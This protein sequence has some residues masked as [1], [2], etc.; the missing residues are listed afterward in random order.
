M[1]SSKFFS[2]KRFNKSTKAKET[3]NVTNSPNA[4]YFKISFTEELNVMRLTDQIDYDVDVDMTAKIAVANTII[5]MW[6]HEVG[7]IEFAKKR[8]NLPGSITTCN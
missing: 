3:S 1:P 5:D 8:A 2:C 6:P 4:T 7:L